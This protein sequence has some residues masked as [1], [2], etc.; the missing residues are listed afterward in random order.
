MRFLQIIPWISLKVLL[1]TPSLIATSSC[2]TPRVMV[3]LTKI[4]KTYICF[5]NSFF[6][7]LPSVEKNSM[8]QACVLAISMKEFLLGQLM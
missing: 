6:C 2:I 8:K 1:D 4:I 3:K 5:Q 7:S